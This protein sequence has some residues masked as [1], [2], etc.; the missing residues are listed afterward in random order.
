MKGGIGSASVRV[1]GVTVGALVA[2]NALGDVLD[3]DTG[4]LLAG[5]RSEDGRRL[6]DTRRALLAGVAP[7]AML[8]AA[9]TTIGV[10]ATDAALT[11]PQAM[12]L[13]QVSHDGL[14]RAINP[15]H[16]LS[17]GDTMFALAT[18]RAKANPSPLVLA[19]AAAEATARATVRAVLM[20]QGWRGAGLELPA[21]REI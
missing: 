13:A 16:T 7:R 19:V 18:G 9:N 11:K 17:D 10:V 6:L 8:A 5:A 21:A 2:C 20:A 1:G 15:V 12:R 14:A 3:P 4:L